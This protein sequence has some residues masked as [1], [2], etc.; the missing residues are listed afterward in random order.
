MVLSQIQTAPAAGA[1]CLGSDGT[2]LPQVFD[3]Y[4]TL[5]PGKRDF[6]TEKL[7]GRDHFWVLS[8]LW[9]VPLPAWGGGGG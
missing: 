1:L 4:R 2:F 7:K 5:N 9:G 3:C 8:R 6:T